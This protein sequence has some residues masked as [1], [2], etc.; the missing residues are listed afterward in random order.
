[1][2][3]TR[4]SDGMKGFWYG[5]RL[6]GVKTL[7]TFTSQHHHSKILR[8]YFTLQGGRNLPLLWRWH[9]HSLLDQLFRFY[10]MKTIIMHEDKRVLKNPIFSFQHW[11]KF[12]SW[13]TFGSVSRTDALRLSQ[14]KWNFAEAGTEYTRD[15]LHISYTGCNRG[16]GPDFGRVFLTLNYTDITQNTYIQSLTVTGIMAIEMCGL[17]G[18]RRTVRRPW[19]HTCPMRTPAR[20]MVMQSPYGALT[21]QDNRSAATCVK[22]LEV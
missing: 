13:E 17:L 6:H 8:K 15:Q 4:V 9:E 12:K 11:R 16:N 18:C 10:E 22:Y 19:R 20:D 2:Y 5:T 14:Y 3:M 7:T 1:M 21:S